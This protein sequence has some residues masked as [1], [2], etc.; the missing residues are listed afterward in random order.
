[1]QPKPAGEQSKQQP[2]NWQSCHWPFSRALSRKLQC[3]SSQAPLPVCTQ[4]LRKLPCHSSQM[5]RPGHWRSIGA[6]YMQ[7][8]MAGTGHGDCQHH[9]T[10]IRP[11]CETCH[12]PA[13]PSTHTAQGCQGPR[14]PLRPTPRGPYKPSTLLST[15]QQLL[16]LLLASTSHSFFRQQ[17]F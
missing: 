11:S 16:L 13:S 8:P 2:D 6:G 5:P 4:L 12:L 7:L 10:F 14:N 1:M 9:P 15:W 17:S 3:H